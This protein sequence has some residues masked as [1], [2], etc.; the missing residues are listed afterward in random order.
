M[1]NSGSF[2][3]ALVGGKKNDNKGRQGVQGNQRKGQE[4]VKARIKQGRR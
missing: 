1:I 4:L 2:P 3:K